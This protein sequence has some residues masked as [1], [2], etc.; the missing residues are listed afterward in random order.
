MADLRASLTSIY[1]KHG[2][3]TP[4]VVVD[5]ARPKTSELHGRFEWDDKVAGEAYRCTQAQELIRSIRINFT[6]NATGER[7]SVR[8]F[9]S[10]RE[11]GDA[12]R[13]GYAPTEEIVQDELATRILQQACKREIADLKRKYGMLEDFIAII[14]GEIEG[15]AS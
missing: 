14:R 5:E 2:E 7:K 12:E 9:H 11:A 13:T 8:A 4:Q 15:L 6:D 1:Q 10:L 3:L